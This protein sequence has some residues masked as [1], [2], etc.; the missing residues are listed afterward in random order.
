MGLVNLKGEKN[1]GTSWVNTG[2]KT[3]WVCMD[4][5]WVQH[6]T[7]DKITSACCLY[8]EYEDLST[9]FNKLSTTIRFCLLMGLTNTQSLK[10]EKRR[11]SL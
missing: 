9:D 7:V 10:W 4:M 8:I 2:V 11:N 3:W 5:Y 6:V 1:K